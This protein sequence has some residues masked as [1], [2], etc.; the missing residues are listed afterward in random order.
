MRCPRALQTRP[1]LRSAVRAFVAVLSPLE[2]RLNRT[3]GTA[4]EPEDKGK[5]HGDVVDDAKPTKNPAKD[6]ERPIQGD[7]AR[8][9]A[10]DET[11]AAQQFP[12]EIDGPEGPEPTRF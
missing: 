11:R 3:L 10:A 8:T 6:E 2:T 12:G 4:A 9:R 7:A 5:H 1:D